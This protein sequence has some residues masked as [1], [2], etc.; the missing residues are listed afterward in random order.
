MAGRGKLAHTVAAPSGD[1]A[2]SPV[3]LIFAHIASADNFSPKLFSPDKALMKARS[4]RFLEELRERVFVGDGA[5]GT[6]LYSKGAD[7]NKCFEELNL[8]MPSLVKE[9][10]E[11]YVRA[12]A[13]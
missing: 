9:V 8:S 10:H 6:V 7:L 13:E 1:C 11:A 2:C 4:S 5:M 12:G 3:P